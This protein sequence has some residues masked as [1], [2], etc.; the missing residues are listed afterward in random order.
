MVSLPTRLGIIAGGGSLPSKLL[1][2]CDSRNIPVFVVG[3]EGQ[4]DPAILS[5]RD[6]MMTRLG[7]AGQIIKTLREKGYQDLVLIGSIRRPH[8]KDLRPDLFTATFFAKLSLRYLGDDNLLKA[9]HGELAREG[10]RLHGIHEL[11]QDLLVPEGILGR[12]RPTRAQETDIAEGYRIARAIGAL[13]IGQSVI[14]QD[15]VILGVE[16][17]E[18]TDELIRRCATYRQTK[19]GGILVK[20]CKPQQDRKIDMP[21]VGSH[22]VK[23]CVDKGL[24]GMAVEAGAA[25]MVDAGEMIR[26]AD[27]SGLFLTG[28][29]VSS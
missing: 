10:F 28:V 9:V 7:S 18:G 25:L 4:T 15:G 8:L 26:L 16:G 14:I 13:D 12:H 5:G 24:H 6:H 17:V 23:L 2:F 19:T 27:E 20:T 3:F 11:M 29:A 21:T 1:G 22:T